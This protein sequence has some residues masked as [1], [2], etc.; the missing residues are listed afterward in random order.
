MNTYKVVIHDENFLE[1]K[2]V[3]APSLPEAST[4]AKEY[5]SEKY[6]T[7]PD[8]VIVSLHTDDIKDKIPEV[9]EFLYNKS[10]HLDN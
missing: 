9:F 6:N 4:K 1:T 3:Q 10:T 7:H 2:L 8:N 5:F